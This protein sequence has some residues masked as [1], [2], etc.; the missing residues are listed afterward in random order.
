MFLFAWFVYWL[1]RYEKE[2]KLLLGVVFIWGAVVAAGFAFIINTVLGMG[3]YL[4]TSS[5][6]ITDFATGSLIAPPVE[7]LLKG[8]AVFAV[9]LLARKEFDSVLDGIIYAGIVALGFAATENTYYIYNYGYLENGW[10]GLF[11]LVFVRVI[12]VGWQ[13]PFY[14]AFVGIGLAIARLNRNWLIKIAAVILGLSVA[15]GLHS[16]HNTI[17]T[18]ASGLGGLVFGTIIDWSGWLV[19]FIIILWAISNVQKNCASNCG[20]K[21]P[22]V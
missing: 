1:D 18:F 13:H 14:T 5:D 4:V 19:M 6:T 10:Q 9:F 15:V 17:A 3:V 16:M 8:F 21:S 2:P 12:L 11:F 7:E 20:K 22:R